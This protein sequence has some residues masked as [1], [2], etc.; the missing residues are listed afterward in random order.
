MPC[1]QIESGELGSPPAMGMLKELRPRYWFSAHHHVK[2][3]ATV[4]HA[5]QQAGA[6]GGGEDPLF[7]NTMT[8]FLALDKCLPKRKFLQVRLL[9]F[10]TQLQQAELVQS[11]GVAA[12]SYTTDLAL[13]HSTQQVAVHLLQVCILWPR[14]CCA[15]DR[16]LSQ[17]T[18]AFR[19]V[20]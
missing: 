17:G 11:A 15:A 12:I 5:S 9:P 13:S 16:G 7:A 8:D 19:T 3:A 6:R 14:C 18:G 10:G 4:R 2:Y 1:L 20:L